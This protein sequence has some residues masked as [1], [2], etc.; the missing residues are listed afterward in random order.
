MPKSMA[1]LGLGEHSTPKSPASSRIAK[2]SASKPKAP[3]IQSV[4]SADR[5]L[6]LLEFVAAENSVNFTQILKDLD[7]PRSSAHGLLKT[8]ISSGWL[9]QDPD[10]KEYSLGLRAW[11]VG[12][13]YRGHF[14]LVGIAKPVMDRLASSVRETV[15]LA[16]LDGIENV[17]IAISE[18]AGHGMQL[19]SRVGGR[20]LAHATG[21][22]KA[23]LSMKDPIEVEELL[24]SSDLPQYTRKTVTDVDQL[25]KL[26]SSVNK[27][28]FAIDD[29]EYASGCRCVAVPLMKDLNGQTLTALSITMP[30]SRTDENW[31]LS[32]VE[33]LKLAAQEIRS[34]VGTTDEK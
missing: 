23:L 2:K 10:S 5:T 7:I 12:Q 16:R 15:Q 4:K 22:G 27:N 19:S 32:I 25:M 26:I 14:Y 8:L 9:G 1:K 20:L 3:Q 6:A 24:R 29:E 13:L 30:T 31:P 34:I 33:P 28:G 21:I 17:Y 18:S 11:Q